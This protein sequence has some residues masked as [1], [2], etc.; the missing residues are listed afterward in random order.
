MAT[1]A[2]KLPPEHLCRLDRVSLKVDDSPEE[3]EPGVFLLTGTATRAGVF[4]YPD[5]MELRPLSEVMDA[6]SLRSYMGAPVTIGHPDP[7]VHPRG[8]VTPENRQELMHGS[9]IAVEPQSDKVVVRMRL[10]SHEAIEA[11]NGGVKEL[12][13]GYALG[14]VDHGEGVDPVY[15]KYDRIQRKIR[16]NHLALVKEARAGDTADVRTDSR[17]DTAQGKY[18]PRE[19]KMPNQDEATVGGGEETRSDVLTLMMDGTPVQISEDQMMAIRM[20]VPQLRD[21]PGPS[22]G[23]GEMTMNM[24]PRQD[25]EFPAAGGEGGEGRQD[26]DAPPGPGGGPEEQRSDKRDPMVPMSQ[27]AKLVAKEVAKG[28][29]RYDSASRK[30]QEILSKAK[31][32]LPE[33]YRMDSASTGKVMAD[34]I[35]ARRSEYK[36]EVEGICSRADSGDRAALGELSGMFR[37]IS[38]D[39]SGGREQIGSYMVPSTNRMDAKSEADVGSLYDEQEGDDK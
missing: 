21:G 34:A 35:I 7:R 5:G 22:E 10:I 25:R 30:R 17:G 12:S 33:G 24:P 36:N 15:G 6:S 13:L 3:I 37:E 26:R 29:E 39:V 27:V 38:R 11:I 31:D 9:I 23:E 19:D 16:I 32:M 20:L 2:D 28:I 18:R 1:T 4:E 8:F 14:Q